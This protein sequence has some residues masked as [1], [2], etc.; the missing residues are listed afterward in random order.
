MTTES[1]NLLAAFRAAALAKRAT[2]AEMKANRNAGFNDI[3][4]DK[5]DTWAALDRAGK[6]AAEAM[7]AWE[8]SENLY[9]D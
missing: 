1:D 8:R 6:A 5:L 4:M 3:P 2:R 9:D 7:I